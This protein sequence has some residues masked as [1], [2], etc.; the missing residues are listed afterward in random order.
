MD[1][2]FIFLATAD[3]HFVRRAKKMKKVVLGCSLL[4]FKAVVCGD[5]E[6]VIPFLAE[7]FNERLAKKLVDS[8]VQF[9]SFADGVV[10]NRPAM[11]LQA[12]LPVSDSLFPNRVEGTGNRLAQ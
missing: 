6:F 3:K 11:I 10:A 2:F 9:A 12:G 7:T 5:A 1:E 4:R 8:Q